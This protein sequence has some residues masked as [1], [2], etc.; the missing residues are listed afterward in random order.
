MSDEALVKKLVETGNSSYF[1]ILYD[2]YFKKVYYQ[3]ISYVKDEEEAQDVSQDIFVKLYD[4]LS[5][6]QGKSSFS[7]WIFS[8]SRNAVLDHLRNKGKLQESKIDESALENIPEVEDDELLALRSDRLAHIL[9][10]IHPDDKAI[11]I[12]MYAHEWKMDEIA[13]HMGMGLSAIKMRIKRAKAKVLA[14][15]TSIYGKK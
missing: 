11:L 8:F 10:Q 2:R 5:K 13:E 3:V 12:M 7:T 6:F 15:H 4:R 1:S 9:D 14:L